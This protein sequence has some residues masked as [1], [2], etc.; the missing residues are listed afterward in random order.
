MAQP[1]KWKLNLVKMNCVCWGEKR[2]KAVF[3]YGIRKMKNNVRIS[4]IYRLDWKVKIKK[5]PRQRQW[6]RTVILLPKKKKNC[7]DFEEDLSFISPNCDFNRS[8]CLMKFNRRKV[9]SLD[10]TSHWLTFTYFFSFKWNKE[11]VKKKS[12]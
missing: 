10:N 8:L 1:W 7:M 12:L 5:L 9:W 11:K 4:E 3:F 2:Q 6:H